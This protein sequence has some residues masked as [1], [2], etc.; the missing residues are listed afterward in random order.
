MTTTD[1]AANLSAYPGVASAT[2]LSSTPTIAFVQIANGV[3][4]TPQSVVTV[5]YAAAQTAGATSAESQNALIKRYC[6]TAC[7]NV[8]A[9][10]IAGL[11]GSRLY[12]GSWSEWVADPARPVARG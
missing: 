1:A 12:P 3:P 4:Q 7:H 5:W 9:M 8:L 10:S 11:P 6:V 2:T